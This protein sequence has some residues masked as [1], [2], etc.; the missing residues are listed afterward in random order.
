MDV[1]L[2][3]GR[4]Q[5]LVHAFE[6][7]DE[8]PDFHEKR[9]VLLA[10]APGDQHS[11]GSTIVQKFLRAAGWHVWTCASER[12]EESADVAAREWFGVIGFSLS[13]D[14]NRAALAAAIARVRKSSLN[15]KVGIMVGGPAIQRNSDWVAEVGADGTAANGPAAVI[16][17][18]KLLAES[19][20]LLQ[21]LADSRTVA[22]AP[23]AGG[24]SSDAAVQADP[25]RLK[26]VLLNLVG[27]AIKYNRP[28]GAVWVHC[29]LQDKAPGHSWRITVQD[30]GPGLDAAQQAR[31][32]GAF[33]RLGAE[34]GAVEGTGLGLA[35]SRGL[36]RAMGGD[37]G[38]HSQPGVGSS[39]W[40]Q[41]PVATPSP[42]APPP[43]PAPAL[44]GP[45][46]VLAA[47]AS[48]DAAGLP[49]VLYVEDNEVNR[50]L[51]EGVFEKLPGLQLRMADSAARGLQMALEQPPRL[52]LL[53]IQLP[54]LD[55]RV[56]L[57]R[58]RQHPQLAQVPVIAV[59]A[60]ATPDVVAEC[61]AAGFADYLTK[62]IDLDRLAAV[63]HAAL[64]PA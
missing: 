23:S 30:T 35:L 48:G 63:L 4:L 14:G 47:E 58:L 5:R 28:R 20:A 41:L 44:P 8:V 31:L 40:V 15:R 6:R 29:A 60:D 49:V 21:P 64:Q 62:P 50:M 34:A 33:D 24:L 36:V 32:F 59:S 56:L 18:K 11:M 52:V 54:D 9:K 10:C 51:M 45:P 43:V 7:L 13:S 2:G 42:G 12:M 53:D 25:V 1:T 27:N 3:V 46:P 39:F 61:R 22:L 57:Q 37:I 55:G 38:V 19:L 16:L 26:Q 17:A